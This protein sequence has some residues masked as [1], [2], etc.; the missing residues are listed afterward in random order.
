MKKIWDSNGY[1]WRIDK[2]I[3]DLS[4]FKGVCDVTLDQIVISG[5][6]NLKIEPF[7]DYIVIYFMVKI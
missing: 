3:E 4:N 7:K 1:R 2:A 5:Q 6:K